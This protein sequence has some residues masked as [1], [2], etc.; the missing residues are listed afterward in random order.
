MTGRAA[1][2]RDEGRVLVRGAAAG[3]IFGTPL[4]YT[5]EMW[6]HGLDL[7]PVRLLGFLGAMIV[8]NSALSLFLGFRERFSPADAVAEGIT[9]VALA[10]LVSV[11]VLLLIGEIRLARPLDGLGKILV[12]ASA[13]SVGVSVA[14]ARFH[15]ADSDATDSDPG[16]PRSREQKEALQLQ[17]DA[18]DVGATLAGAIVFS[19]NTAPTE[20]VTLIASRL[21]PGQLLLLLAAEIA[22]A[23]LVLFA[24]GFWKREVHLPDSLFQKPAA[25]T[26][27]ATGISLAVAAVLVALVGFGT[28]TETLS[29]FASRTV[30]LALPAC[31]GGAAGRLV[32]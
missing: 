4:L 17:Q 28:P 25:E 13:V 1:G 30:V 15:H 20:E 9:S 24:S 29:T 10:A 32:L 5:M 18:K 11:A 3:I 21:S 16:E 8:A 22:I 6:W 7:S 2:W 27:V 26:L 12:E 14:N 31:I 23:Y 19:M